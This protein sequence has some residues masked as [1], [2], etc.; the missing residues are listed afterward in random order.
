MSRAEWALLVF[1]SVLWGGSFF[2]S[3]VAVAALPPLTIVFFRFATAALLVYAYAR[4]RSIPIP[5][6]LEAGYR[7][8]AWACLTTS[9]L[10]A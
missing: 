7:S 3:K 10:P 6:E 8:R 4:A 2:F 9:F 1:L 5:S